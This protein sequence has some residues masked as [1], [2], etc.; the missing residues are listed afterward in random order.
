MKAY[1]AKRIA[2]FWLVLTVVAVFLSSCKAE[3]RDHLAYQEYPIRAECVLSVRDG[4]YPIILDII[5]RESAR[6]TFVGGRLEGGVIEISGGSAY[7][8]NAGCR[9]PLTLT[10]VSPLSAV[11]G[12]FDLSSSDMTKVTESD[13]ALTVDYRVDELSVNVILRD[14]IPTAMEL[15][16]DGD[17]YL[18]NFNNFTSGKRYPE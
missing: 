11:V 9:I 15:S 8:I 12:V 18:L 5:S 4:D 13:D 1:F 7:L 3:E 14:N 16:S 2:V 17:I 10:D 6:V